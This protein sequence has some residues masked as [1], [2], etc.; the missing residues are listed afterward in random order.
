MKSKSFTERIA[1][2][3]ARLWTVVKIHPVEILI[4]LH[5]TIATVS[6]DTTKFEQPAPYAAIATMVAFC[7]SRFRGSKAWVQWLYFAILPIYALTAFFPIAWPET[8]EF[9]IVNFLLPAVYLLTL[10]TQDNARF[11]ERFYR[12]IRSVVIAIGVVSILL[13]ILWLINASVEILFGSDFRNFEDDSAAWC[14]IFLAPLLFIALESRKEQP[15]VIRLVEGIINYVFTP[16][17]LIYNLILYAYLALIL[18]KWELPKGSVSTM[19][20]SFVIVAVVIRLENGLD[21][22]ERSYKRRS[23]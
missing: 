21:R 9:A 3:I 22:K 2:G 17:L 13:I 4:L 7:L 5:A 19:V 10:P 11:T 23:I 1:N 20:M 12:F 8:S 14:Y 15:K 16:A 18:V 6:S